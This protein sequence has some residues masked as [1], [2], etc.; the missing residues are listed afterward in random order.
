MTKQHPKYRDKR[1]Y[2]KIEIFEARRNGE[3]HYVAT[4][5]WARTL[6][7]AKQ[8]YCKAKG[9]DTTAGVRTQYKDVRR[10][11]VKR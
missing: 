9:Y 5:T 10:P 1:D 7:E 11:Y 3:W 8:E 4:T 2:P 6:T